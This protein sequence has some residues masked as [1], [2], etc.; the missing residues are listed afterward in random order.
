MI[1]P[2]QAIRLAV[3]IGITSSLMA[4]A[5]AEVR[6]PIREFDDQGYHVQLDLARQVVGIEI[7]EDQDIGSRGS[8]EAPI[9]PTLKGISGKFISGSVLSQKAKQFDDGLYAAIE[10]AA[11]NGLGR[12]RGKG[13]MLQAIAKALATLESV[14]PESP[15]AIVLAAGRLGNPKI[16]IPAPAEAAVK[17]T[18]TSFLG[19]PLRSKPIGF[20]TWTPA[21]G[22]IF[23]Q[24]RMLQ[25]ELKGSAE[26]QTLAR[27]IHANPEA[28]ATYEAY[29]SLTSRMTNPLTTDSLEGR[30]KQL[31]QGRI[32]P[33][34][35]KL[36]FFPAS[37]AHETDLILRLYGNRPIPEGF[38]LVDEMVKRIQ[39][40]TLDLRPSR[41]SGWYDYQTWALEP[42][43]IPERMPEASHLRT[44][45]SYRKQLL[46]LF[47]G[48]LALTRET[49]IKQLSI[50]AAGAA[51][52]GQEPATIHI[53][54]ELAAEPLPTYYLRRGESYR[55]IRSVLE[56]T[57]GPETL[58]QIHRE[59]ASGAV[60]TDLA[61]ELEQMQ[62]LFLG[63]S[64]TVSQQLGMA[65]EGDRAS[66]QRWADSVAS[67]PDLTK[68][69]RMMVPVFFDRGRNQTKVW[70]FLGWSQRPV[71]LWFVTPPSVE[72]TR[73]GRKVDLKREVKLDFEPRYHSLPYPV[74]AEV[75]VTRI[76]DR[77]EFR[78]HCDRH[79]TRAMILENLR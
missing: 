18:I 67:D 60:A 50:P 14:K 77:D 57:F 25:S 15:P 64:A 22:A 69:A 26:I 79:Q 65:N 13:P 24:D 53:A 1:R 3:L 58:R 21:L 66:F 36:A 11:Q 40:G 6:M 74:T 5:P 70:V 20:Y 52:P 41:D 72:V 16:L 31:D 48:I 43:V 63:A 2:P 37:R 28:R 56:D 55:F 54:P 49:H 12:F 4:A 78:R 47:K 10:L 23:R 62:G 27:L 17:A 76:L 75:Y 33:P 71:H 19:D 46:E 42:L 39:G 34:E 9:S 45:P 38:R 32:S 29:L 35:R 44:E 61:T 59:T 68:D 8:N 30:L 51:P 73:N 7:P